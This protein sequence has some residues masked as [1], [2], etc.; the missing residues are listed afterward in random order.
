MRKEVRQLHGCLI[1]CSLFSKIEMFRIKKGQI[2]DCMFEKP[3]HFK[4]KKSNKTFHLERYSK[5]M[6]GF[7]KAYTIKPILCA[8]ADGFLSLFAYFYEMILLLSNILSAI[9]FR[10]PKAL[11]VILKAPKESLIITMKHFQKAADD[12]LSLKYFTCIQ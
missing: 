8:C 6:V 4:I 5:D 7:L 1:V 3:H 2:R 9:L 12:I 11:I 10:R